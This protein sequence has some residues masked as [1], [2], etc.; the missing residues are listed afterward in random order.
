VWEARELLL[1]LVW[2]DISVRYKQTALGVAWALLQP[3][4][5]MIVFSVLFGRLA[6]LPSDGISYPLFAL[7]GLLPWQLFS[8]ALAGSAAS[9]VANERLVAKV[10]FPRLMIPLAPVLAGLVDLALA[11]PLLFGIMLYYRVPLSATALLAP[12]FV[13]LAALTAAA[14]G[15]GLAA[16]NARYRDVRHTMP[17]MIQLWLF[18]TP[19]AYPSTL[20]PSEWRPLF[21]LNPM[22][23]A[24]EGFR[25]AVCGG[26]GLSWQLVGVSITVLGLGVWLSLAYFFR[27]ERTL[28]DVI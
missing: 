14:A 17:F 28:A 27:V 23:A 21:A 9:L 13:L 1:F 3:L 15:I 22:S 26:P 20:I 16:L 6:K 8:Q 2:R 4:L 7:S 19:I 10:Y 24:V 11:L 12:L 25:W 5:T 18:L